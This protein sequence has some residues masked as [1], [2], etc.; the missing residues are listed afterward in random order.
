M[1]FQWLSHLRA[2]RN[3]TLQAELQPFHPR[4]FDI[5]T[6]S[7]TPIPVSVPPLVHSY[8]AKAPLTDLI[9]SAST[10]EP[11]SL[12]LRSI[13]VSEGIALEEFP[14]TIID[15]RTH[16]LLA[17]DY[18]VVHIMECHECVDLSRSRYETGIRSD[19]SPYIR[20]FRSIVPSAECLDMGRPLF[21]LRE[22]R[23]VLLVHERIKATLT[24]NGI[25]G[26]RFVPLD[27]LK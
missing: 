17:D 4:W 27:Q 14:T 15:R 22:L 23:S 16:Q 9:W 24:E 18:A 20:R 8:Y 21:R 6:A 19:G 2:W 5:D 11:Y 25:T 26:V 12:R 10:W 3:T 13:L 7:C 1:Y